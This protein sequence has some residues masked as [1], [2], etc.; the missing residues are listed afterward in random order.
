MVKYLDKKQTA[1]AIKQNKSDKFG[2]VIKHARNSKGLTI[3]KV[4]SWIIKPNGI[5]M[6]VQYLSDIER[7]TKLP[8]QPWFIQQ[9][10]CHLDIDED[11]MYYLA[12]RFPYLEIMQ[13]LGESEFKKCMKRFRNEEKI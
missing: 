12:G 5:S 11:W 6:S 7:G 8:S 10:A 13:E 1:L 9:I 2:T 4:S 3:A